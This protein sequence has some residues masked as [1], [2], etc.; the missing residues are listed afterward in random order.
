M[1]RLTYKQIIYLQFFVTYVLEHLTKFI[2]RKRIY[3]KGGDAEVPSI[4]R[5]FAAMYLL[6]LVQEVAYGN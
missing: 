6:V 4:D 5:L 3:M 2:S 1:R